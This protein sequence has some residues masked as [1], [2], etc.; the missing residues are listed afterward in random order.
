ME[1]RALEPGDWEA[2]NALREEALNEV[3]T[4]FGATNTEEVAYRKARFEAMEGHPCNFILG[5]FAEGSMLGMI[6][7]V[8][9]EKV[10]IRHK[11]AIWGMYVRSAAQRQ[12]IG[13]QLME[14]ALEKA[15]RQ[16][17]L[18]QIH[19]EVNAANVAALRLYEALGFHSYGLEKE[20]MWVEGEGQDVIHMARKI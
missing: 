8:R 17:G 1:I 20:A 5:A 18:R 2:Y 9:W 16:E 12:G 11:A 14:A 19:L 7:F 6:G 10:K 15:K 4:A 3:P 13:R